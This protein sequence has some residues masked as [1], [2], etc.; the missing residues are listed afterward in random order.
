LGTLLVGSLLVAGGAAAFSLQVAGFQVG[1]LVGRDGWPFLVIIPGLILLAGAAVA[2]RPA[3]VSLAIAGSIVTTVGAILLY[4]NVTE[5][6]ESW[7]YV[8]ALIPTAAG[9]AMAVYG[10]AVGH[11]GLVLAGGRLALVGAVLF[12]AGLWFFGSLFSNGEVPFDLGAWWPAVPI[13]IGG[14][15]LLSAIG[16]SG[17]TRP[18]Q[19]LPR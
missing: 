13:V 12:L 10:T 17:T 19:P 5:D 11:D 14:A 16:G 7:A 2:T 4:Q 8:W 3:G 15:I 9:V 1:E 18:H 6:W